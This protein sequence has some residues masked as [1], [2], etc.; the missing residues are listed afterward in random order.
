MVQWV[1]LSSR[2][3]LL[4]LKCEQYAEAV[5]STLSFAVSVFDLVFQSCYSVAVKRQYM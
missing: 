4:I 2:F 1:Y 5:G 3:S